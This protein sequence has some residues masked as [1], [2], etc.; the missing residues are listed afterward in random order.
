M[1]ISPY[2]LIN[3]YA[4]V[5]AITQ[6]RGIKHIKGGMADYA[7]ALIMAFK[8]LGGRLFCDMPINEIAIKDSKAYGVKTTEKFIP[9]I[10]IIHLTLTKALLLTKIVLLTLWLG[11]QIL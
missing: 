7:T 1:G 6:V 4:S 9:Y 5:P 10:F 8:D 11:C 2:K 3:V